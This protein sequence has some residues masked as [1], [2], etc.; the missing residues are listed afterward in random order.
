MEKKKKRKKKTKADGGKR[1]RLKDWEDGSRAK[2]DRVKERKK[3]RKKDR[4]KN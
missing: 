4:R 1:D 3:E 2:S